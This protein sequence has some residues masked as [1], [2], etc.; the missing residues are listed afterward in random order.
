MSLSLDELKKFYKLRDKKPDLYTYD[1]N[2]DLIEKDKDRAVKKT[3]TLPTYRKPTLEELD[4]MSQKRMTN[5][6]E[7][8]QEYENAREQLRQAMVTPDTMVS[9]ILRI[10]RKVVEAD[11]KLQNI[12]FP[13]RYV[14]Q[15]ESVEVRNV[16]FDQK[17][18][19]RKLPNELN[20]LITR[21]FTLQE[22]Y[23][24][25][26]SPAETPIKSVQEIRADRLKK[27]QESIKSVPIILFSEP[28][29]NDYGFLSMKWDVSLE[30]QDETFTSAF[31]ALMASMAIY[32]EDE[33]NLQR[34]LEATDPDEITYNYTDLPGD[35]DENEMKWNAKLKQLLYDINLAKFTQH[36]ELGQKLI[37]TGSAKLGYYEPN[38][39][40]LGIGISIE[41][42]Q[43]KN[44][45]KWSGQNWL[46][47]ALEQVRA[48][49][50][51][52]R[53]VQ[54]IPRK[55]KIIAE[56]TTPKITTAPQIVPTPQV[57]PRIAPPPQPQGVP[58]RRKLRVATVNPSE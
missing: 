31:Q 32:F 7:T 5:I 55:S 8:E 53:M 22:Q 33:V 30:I 13:L 28:Y 20:I 26:G 50:L 34:I 6:A 38:E 40:I 14:I 44:P 45:T 27:Q 51:S 58:M 37:Q 24:R 16:L 39:N 18:E 46:G 43:A 2:G 11:M 36:P 42:E 56:E 10:N 35:T 12:R 21:P 52:T 54:G 19:T 25:I 47:N 9:D 29:T 41:K 23:V 1:D 4:E 3:I 17:N 48:Q 15:Q 57:I 49:L